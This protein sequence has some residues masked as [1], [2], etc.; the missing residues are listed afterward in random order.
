MLVS[1]TINNKLNLELR[2]NINSYLKNFQS[3]ARTVRLKRISMKNEKLDFTVKEDQL[4]DLR[5]FIW[6]CRARGIAGKND[7]FFSALIKEKFLNPL[8]M[9]TEKGP[10]FSPFQNVIVLMLKNNEIRKG[11]LYS[12]NAI[13]TAGGKRLYGIKFGVG[14]YFRYEKYKFPYY[15]VD[16]LE[17]C[18]KFIHSLDCEPIHFQSERLQGHLSDTASLEYFY[19]K[20]DCSK[21]A[22]DLVLSF[23][24]FNGLRSCLASELRVNDPMW[25][26]FYYI[27]R[28]PRWRREELLGDALIYQQIYFLD[29]VLRDFGQAVFDKEIIDLKMLEARNSG[30]G[31]KRD[32]DY[33]SGVDLRSIVSTLFDFEEWI[34]TSDSKQYVEDGDVKLL[35]SFHKDLFALIENMGLTLK[36]LDTDIVFSVSEM[37]KKLKLEDLPFHLREVT[38]HEGDEKKPVIK[39]N[40]VSLALCHYLMDLQRGLVGL[41]IRCERRVNSEQ[42]YLYDHRYVPLWRGGIDTPEKIE[43]RL[44][45][46]NGVRDHL[47]DLQKRAR[48]IF[49]QRCREKYV[50]SLEYGNESEGFLCDDCVEKSRELALSENEDHVKMFKNRGEAKWICDAC[51]EKM[52]YKFVN[53]NTFIFEGK[54][55]DR[56]VVTLNY[57]QIEIEMRCNGRK[58]HYCGHVSRKVF[59]FGWV[60]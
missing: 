40:S 30:I 60:R 49:C 55:E 50:R 12:P 44:K 39:K 2:W 14:S 3:I 38:W 34:K 11:R 13:A 56:P 48:R 52:L 1:R 27:D 58:G 15:F 37:S 35:E 51:G 16:V 4:L 20:V 26:W 47:Y 21:V 24:D 17:K 8:M 23:E 25:N 57:G 31:S 28:H 59:N 9:H 36:D 41:I 32:D 5:N 7:D 54:N 29:Y 45:F 19:D 33:I 42:S 46:C 6:Y 22:D 10:L 43:E 53:K 18:L